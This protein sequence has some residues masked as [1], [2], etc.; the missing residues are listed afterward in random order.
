MRTGFLARGFLVFGSLTVSAGYGPDTGIPFPV[1]VPIP[2]VETGLPGPTST[3]P[4]QVSPE[5]AAQRP[6]DVSIPLPPFSTVGSVEPFGLASAQPS[7]PPI[8]IELA[9]AQVSSPEVLD[10]VVTSSAQS[11][12]RSPTARANKAPSGVAVKPTTR[13]SRKVGSSARVPKTPEGTAKEKKE[14]SVSVEFPK[15][16]S[17]KKPSGRAKKASS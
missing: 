8:P 3:L 12:T 13:S 9:S 15:R 14:G 6:D 17:T 4:F 7:Q 10:A 2:T 5:G 11:R 16:A 1:P